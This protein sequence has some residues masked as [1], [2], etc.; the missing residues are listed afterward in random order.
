MTD[1]I[2]HAGDKAGW[3][4]ND[5]ALQVRQTGGSHRKNRFSLLCF[6]LPSNRIMSPG[7]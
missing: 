1:E 3:K 6:W 5:E 2:L 4:E 7:G